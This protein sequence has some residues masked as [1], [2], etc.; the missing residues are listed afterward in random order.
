MGFVKICAYPKWNLIRQRH[1]NCQH[2]YWC[3]LT[4]DGWINFDDIRYVLLFLSDEK[5]GT[6]SN[7]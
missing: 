5:I 6:L 3:P 4:R 2:F 7:L 1:V